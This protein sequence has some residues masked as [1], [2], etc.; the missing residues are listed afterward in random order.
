MEIYKG[1]KMLQDQTGETTLHTKEKR[2]SLLPLN[3]F[4]Y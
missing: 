4:P 1:Q 3:V 2:V